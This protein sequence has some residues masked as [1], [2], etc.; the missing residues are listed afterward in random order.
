MIIPILR[1]VSAVPTTQSSLSEIDVAA[2]AYTWEFTAQ[3][4]LVV[5]T[6]LLLAFW[7]WRVW[8]AENRLQDAIR[9]DAETRIA[10]AQAEA[11]KANERTAELALKVEEEAWRRAEA[12][13][14]L[15]EVQERLAWRILTPAQRQIFLQVLGAGP[16]GGVMLLPSAEVPEAFNF[17]RQIQDLLRH[18]GWDTHLSTLGQF[19]GAP[20]IGLVLTVP[21]LTAPSPEANLLYRAFVS[22]GLAVTVMQYG[23]L[24][25][26]RPIGLRVGHKP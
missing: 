24:D 7:P 5:V 22:A 12:E 21:D 4:V 26:E 1:T 13:R 15:A 17:A 10:A 11:A 8:R 23:P 20:T 16:K 19:G 2:K 6:A 9:L 25:P 18:A 14:A 3:M